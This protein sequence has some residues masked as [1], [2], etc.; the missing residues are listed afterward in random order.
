MYEGKKSR[1]MYELKSKTNFLLFKESIKKCGFIFTQNFEN[2][3]EEEPSDIFENEKYILAI[4][5]RADRWTVYLR[6]K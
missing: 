3:D 5:P 2:R 4:Q 1:I 6:L